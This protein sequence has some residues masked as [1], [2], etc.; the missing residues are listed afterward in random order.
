MNSFNLKLPLKDSE[1]AIKNKLINSLSELQSDNQ[2]DIAPFIRT[3]QQTQLL[4]K[5]VLMKYLNQS[6]VLLYQTYKNL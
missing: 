1:S 6:I 4:K 2:S 3:Q 5:V